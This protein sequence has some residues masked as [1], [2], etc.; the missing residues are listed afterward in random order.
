MARDR[1]SP[2]RI[3]RKSDFKGQFNA[4]LVFPIQCLYNIIAKSLQSL[5][6]FSYKYYNTVQKTQDNWTLFGRSRHSLSQKAGGHWQD[7]NIFQSLFRPQGIPRIRRVDF[8]V[9]WSL[10][11]CSEPSFC[12]G[13]A[14]PLGKCDQRLWIQEKWIAG[15]GFWMIFAKFSCF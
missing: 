2:S 7:T 11:S 10:D 3:S 9:F 13:T 5:S 8:D 15:S 14:A 6:G 12:L 1:K 4:V